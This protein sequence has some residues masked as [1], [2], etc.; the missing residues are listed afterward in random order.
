M[1]CDDTEDH[2]VQPLLVEE[3]GNQDKTAK[4]IRRYLVSTRERGK[5][6]M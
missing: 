1:R 6:W 4:E 3:E 2:T 5:L